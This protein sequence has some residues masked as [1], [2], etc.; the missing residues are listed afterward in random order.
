MV[1]S[2]VYNQGV[3]DKNF[4]YNAKWPTN[5]AIRR[6]EFYGSSWGSNNPGFLHYFRVD[7]PLYQDY[8]R[9]IGMTTGTNARQTA[10]QYMGGLGTQQTVAANQNA[11]GYAATRD[12]NAALCLPT[13]F[14][15][16]CACVDS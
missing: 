13:V 6:D 12:C 2:F 15:H 5:D 10:N 14:G 4:A 16:A 7:R 9:Y 1:Y 11:V 8:N 3:P